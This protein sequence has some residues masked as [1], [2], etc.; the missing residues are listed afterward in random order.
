LSPQLIGLWRNGRLCRHFHLSLQSG[1]DGVLRRM[2]RGYTAGGYLEAVALIRDMVPGAAITTDVIV[3]FPGET[4]AD[5][6]ASYQL[7]QQAN[8]ARIHVF[9]YSPRAGTQA[10]LMPERVGEGV[11]RERSQRLLALAQESARSFRQGFLDRT[12]AVLWEGQAGGVWTGLTDNY[13]RVYAKSSEDLTNRLL[14]ARLMEIKGDG[15]WG[16]LLPGKIGR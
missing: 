7:C 11:K 2:R 5:F 13:I 3:G 14:P 10:A 12:M 6:E 16:N 9:P 4:E 1:S 15:V 8:F